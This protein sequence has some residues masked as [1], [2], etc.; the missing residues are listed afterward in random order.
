MGFVED[1]RENGGD[2]KICGLVPKV[3]QVFELLG[4]Q[5]LYHIVESRSD[6]IQ[7]F[8]NVPVWEG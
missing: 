5:E 8:A 2:I 3:F 4:F 7:K 1:V 6:A